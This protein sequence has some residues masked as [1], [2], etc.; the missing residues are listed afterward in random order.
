VKTTKVKLVAAAA[1]AGSL[2]AMGGLTVATSAAEPDPPTPGPVVPGEIT[3]G[4]TTTI[5]TDATTT[6]STTVSVEPEIRGPAPLP[7]EQA[8]AQ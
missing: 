6:T 7:S 2:L 4:E 8:D 5:Q 1:G 3:T